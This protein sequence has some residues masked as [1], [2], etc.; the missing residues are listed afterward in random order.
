MVCTHENLQ[1]DVS[2]HVPESGY[3]RLPHE[4]RLAAAITSRRARG[5]PES[6]PTEDDLSHTF[7]GPLVLPNDLLSFETDSDRPQSLDLWFRGGYR[8][9][10]SQRRKTIYIAQSPTIP[11]DIDRALSRWVDTTPRVPKSSLP[12]GI[13]P[14]TVSPPKVEDICDYLR[15]F[16][17]PLEVKQA[18]FTLT[19]G[20]WDEASAPG[21]TRHKG[22]AVQLQIDDRVAFRIRARPAPDN[23]YRGQLNLSDILDVSLEALPKDAYALILLIDQDMYEDEEDNFCC[24][25]AYG[26]SR[27]AVVSSSRYNPLLDSISGIE[28]EH[29]WPASHCKDFVDS[30]CQ[31]SSRKTKRRKIEESRTSV[32]STFPIQAAL[33]AFIASKPE[34]DDVEALWFSRMSLTVAHELGHCFAFAHCPYYA[35]A[36]QGTGSIKEDM[37]QPPYLCPVCLAKVTKAIQGLPPYQ[38]VADTHYHLDRY[39]ALLMFCRADRWKDVKRFASFGAW[40]EQRIKSLAQAQRKTVLDQENRS[41]GNTKPNPIVT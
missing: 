13:D 40:L 5:S 1:L 6:F 8:N 12:K 28:R 32:D 16:Y 21:N 11:Q 24:G 2:S 33:D 4:Q 9:A 7:P 31:A 30:M 18:P 38:G 41:T 27:V 39:Q 3:T 20:K 34:D 22:S 19:Y 25:R 10:L 15:A 37:R 17:H 14:G 26:G 35:C 23:L 36:M 29:A